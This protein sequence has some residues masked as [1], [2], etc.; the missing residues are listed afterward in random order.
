MKIFSSGIIVSNTIACNECR[1]E[2]D[3]FSTFGLENVVD[4]IAWT[5]CDAAVSEMKSRI[6]R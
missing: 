4:S 5:Y 2:Y 3:L 1:D 6:A